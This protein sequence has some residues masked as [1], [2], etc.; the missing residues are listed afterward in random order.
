MSSPQLWI[1]AG[2]N[3]SGKTTLTMRHTR[4]F[5]TSISVVNPDEIAKSIDPIYM[6]SP[7]VAI[8]A[9]KTA[10]KQQRRLLGSRKSFLVETTFSGNH[11]LRLIEKAKEQGYKVNL[12]YIALRDATRNIN[13]VASRVAAGGHNIPTADIIRRY[14]RSLQNAPKGIFNADR[15]F[16]VD[17]SRKRHQ[18]LFTRKHG[19]IQFVTP[20]KLQPE[21]SNNILR[22]YEQEQLRA[23]QQY[24]GN[25]AKE[26]Q[27]A[28]LLN[29]ML[30][31]DIS[32]NRRIKK[33]KTFS[34]MLQAIPPGKPLPSVDGIIRKMS[35]GL[36]R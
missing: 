27:L 15:S 11:E 28:G 8:Q 16:I 5:P 24:V 9:G 33:L 22:G 13:R 12:I 10:L 6:D 4:R 19:V 2:P 32:L 20:E 3:G 7:Q 17:N 26:E 25:P 29:G 36:E 21:W 35:Q 34:K 18:L 14:G 1:V 31:K 23:L 30:G